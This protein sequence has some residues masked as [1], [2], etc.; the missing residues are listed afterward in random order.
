MASLISLPP[1]VLLKIFDYLLPSDPHDVENKACLR[2]LRVSC[3]KL[4]PP[5]SD[6]FYRHWSTFIGVKGDIFIETACIKFLS[7][8]Q[9]VA[10][11]VQSIQISAAVPSY[12]EVS[13]LILLLDNRYTGS[14]FSMCQNRRS[15]RSSIQDITGICSRDFNS[16]QERAVDLYFQKY[17]RPFAEVG[18]AQFRLLGETMELKDEMQKRLSIFPCL[19]YIEFGLAK[20][21]QIPLSKELYHFWSTNGFSGYEDRLVRRAPRNEHTSLLF[22]YQFPAVKAGL[23]SLP[24]L[25]RNVRIAINLYERNELS[26]VLP[27]PIQSQLRCLHIDVNAFKD[28]NL[29]AV[30]PMQRALLWLPFV[31]QFQTLQTLKINQLARPD[32]MDARLFREDCQLLSL[33]SEIRLP[34][35]RHLCLSQVLLSEEYAISLSTKLPQLRQ[36]ELAGVTIFCSKG[37]NFDGYPWLRFADTIRSEYQGSCK[38]VFG[39]SQFIEMDCEYGDLNQM[40]I[41]KIQ[42]FEAQISALRTLKPPA[43]DI[44]VSVS[45]SMALITELEGLYRYSMAHERPKRHEI[46]LDDEIMSDKRLKDLRANIVKHASR[47][48]TLGASH[49]YYPWLF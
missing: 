43:I 19:Q 6:L 36:L 32:I 14:A 31:N 33:L 39:E 13:R 35:L 45:T 5:A 25:L 29:F 26:R 16:D 40:I 2:N 27:D 41:G 8:N 46:V 11:L 47:V 3:K 30:N 23:Q 38:L 12:Y 48:E 24:P 17:Y 1:E 18:Q 10:R 15:L 7:G 20:Y 37:R 21:E 49:C 42:N 34:N 28:P 9:E 4:N 22:E 44:L